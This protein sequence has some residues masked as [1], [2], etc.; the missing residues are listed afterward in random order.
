M[1]IYKDC[2]RDVSP[3]SLE[4]FVSRVWGKGGHKNEENPVLGWTRQGTTGRV[5]VETGVIGVEDVG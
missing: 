1:I 4:I 5:E 2:V 3:N